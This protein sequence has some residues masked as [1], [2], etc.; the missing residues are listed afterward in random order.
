MH[1][2]IVTISLSLELYK[3]SFVAHILD[4]LTNAFVIQTIDIRFRLPGTEPRQNA[5]ETL[6]FI[7]AVQLHGKQSEMGT[8][9]AQA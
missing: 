9:Q 3:L 8:K 6:S 2:L 1:R 7:C 5:R 4:S